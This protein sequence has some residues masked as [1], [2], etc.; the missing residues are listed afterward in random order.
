MTSSTSGDVRLFENDLALDGSRLPSDT[1]TEE[2]RGDL[3][4]VIDQDTI[5]LGIIEEHDLGGGTDEEVGPPPSFGTTVFAGT[6]NSY[7]GGSR[8]SILEQLERGIRSLEFDFHDN[9]FRD[10]GDYRVGHHSPGGEVEHGNGNPR[11]DLLTDWLTVVANWSQRHTDH[12]PI[13]MIL[14]AKDNL[15]DNESRI[16][17]N[18]GN[19]NASLRSIFGDRIYTLPL[20]DPWPSWSELR[21]KLFWYCLAILRRDEP[22]SM[23]RGI[24]QHWR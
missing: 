11:G 4:V 1:E 22:I 3:S 14:D 16:D 17:G 21:V 18:L 9:D 8:G 23:M 6:H 12:A 15:R 2:P 13:T 24:R 10:Y 7:S 5:D 20:N 19:L